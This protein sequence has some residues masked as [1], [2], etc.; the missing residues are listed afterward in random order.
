LLHCSTKKLLYG[1]INSFAECALYFEFGLKESTE[2]KD[3]YR[4]DGIHVKFWT[5]FISALIFSE[6]RF[7][8][9]YGTCGW[10][11]TTSTSSIVLPSIST[12]ILLFRLGHESITKIFAPL[13]VCKPIFLNSDSIKKEIINTRINA[14]LHIICRECFLNF[15]NV[16]LLIIV[17][18]DCA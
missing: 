10:Y 15:S 4:F 8:Q 17:L 14:P 9:S 3:S 2:P 1:R 16:V 5:K 6:R 13:K 11:E 12:L 18:M 7:F